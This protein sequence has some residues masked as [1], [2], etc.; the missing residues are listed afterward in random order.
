MNFNFRG[1]VQYVLVLKFL[2][3]FLTPKRLTIHLLRSY[4][5]LSWVNNTRRNQPR[6]LTRLF[7]PS[8]RGFLADSLSLGSPRLLFSWSGD[9]LTCDATATLARGF[10]FIS[11]AHSVRQVDLVIISEYRWVEIST[12]L[13]Q[14]LFCTSISIVLYRLDFRFCR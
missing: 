3:I 14:G 10:S 1:K 12:G 5:E 9:I 8:Q 11:P 7:R 6:H 4:L 2:C 13:A